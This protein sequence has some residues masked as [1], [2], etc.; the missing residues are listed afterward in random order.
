[1]GVCRDRKELSVPQLF[2]QFTAGHL[3]YKLF[4]LLLSKSHKPRK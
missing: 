4:L 1:M 3:I 2:L